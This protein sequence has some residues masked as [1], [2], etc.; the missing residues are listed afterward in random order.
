MVVFVIKVQHSFLSISDPFRDKLDIRERFTWT[1]QMAVQEK[2]DLLRKLS[3]GKETK[4][5]EKF[6]V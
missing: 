3:G 2:D 5:S 6:F 4:Y 1:L